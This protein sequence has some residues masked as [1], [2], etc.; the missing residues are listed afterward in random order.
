MRIRSTANLGE[1]LKQRREAIGISKQRALS[2]AELPRGFLT[3]LEEGNQVTFSHLIELLN[4]LGGSLRISFLPLQE[5]ADL[6]GY[7]KRSDP[8]DAKL[9]L[10]TESGEKFRKLHPEIL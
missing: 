3:L 1:L 4:L 7:L 2:E 6:T 10:P 5:G 8:P 9:V